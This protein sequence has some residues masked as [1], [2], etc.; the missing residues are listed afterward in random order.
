MDIEKQDNGN[1]VL[2]NDKGSYT[3]IDMG[4][5]VGYGS[6]QWYESPNSCWRLMFFD[7][8]KEESPVHIEALVDTLGD[9]SRILVE[10]GDFK[11][12]LMFRGNIVDEDKI[13]EEVPNEL[14][15]TKN[16]YVAF[17]DRYSEKR[18]LTLESY[19]SQAPQFVSKSGEIYDGAI[20]SNDYLIDFLNTNIELSKTV[21]E[22]SLSNQRS[23]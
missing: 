21:G 13:F 20:A 16:V 7:E 12:V 9:Y 14:F 10:Q 8:N 22:A 11:R 23:L 3:F 2:N 18:H 4:N 19:F 17:E 15:S 6:R 1:M 5:Y